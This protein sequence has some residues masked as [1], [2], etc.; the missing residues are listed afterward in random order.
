MS[1]YTLVSSWLEVDTSAQNDPA[2][3]NHRISTNNPHEVNSSDV[4]L[5]QVDNT[6]DVN[7]P[8]SQD[9]QTK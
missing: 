4:G 1:N 8:I 9:A 3:E 2:Q 7:K 6:S 5:D